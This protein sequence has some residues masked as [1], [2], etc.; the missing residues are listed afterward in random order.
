MAGGVHDWLVVVI[1]A[2]R[3]TLT[4]VTNMS[5][6]GRVLGRGSNLELTKREGVINRQPLASIHVHTSVR[7]VITFSFA[8]KL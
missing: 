5:L 3:K 8:L 7:I 2:C 4:K 1:G 6:Q